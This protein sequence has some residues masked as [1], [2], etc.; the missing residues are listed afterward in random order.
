M[1]LPTHVVLVRKTLSTIRTLNPKTIPF[2]CNE[3]WGLSCLGVT[4]SLRGQTLLPAL[5]A[6]LGRDNAKVHATVTK[7]GRC[8]K[9]TGMVCAFPGNVEGSGI[10]HVI[11]RPKALLL[12]RIQQ[13]DLN[14]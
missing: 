10:D 5:V 13:W 2:V 1:G 11:L 8:V 12:P 3:R 14:A 4:L 6:I 7:E 9:C